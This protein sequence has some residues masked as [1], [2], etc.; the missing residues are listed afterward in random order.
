MMH[1]THQDC[2]V[3]FVRE[4]DR[5]DR[6]EMSERELTTCATYDEAKAVRHEFSG[7]HRKCIIRFVGPAG[8]GD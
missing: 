3:V 6:H 4:T 2:F 5:R 8:G 1:D 7:P